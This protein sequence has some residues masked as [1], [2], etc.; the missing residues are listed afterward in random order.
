MMLSRSARLSARAALSR[1]APVPAPAVSRGAR[2]LSTQPAEE[3]ESDLKGLSKEELRKRATA[4]AA[5]ERTDS[6]GRPGAARADDMQDAADKVQSGKSGWQKFMSSLVDGI[7]PVTKALAPGL[8]PILD[9]PSQRRG[10]E[11]ANIDDLRIAAE[12]RAHAMVFGYLAGGADDERS[13]RR[14]VAAYNDVELR[15][16][17]LH[18]VGNAD[19]DLT[20]KILGH[21]HPLPFFITS[22]AGQRMFHADG[23]VATAKAAKKHN[24]HMALS[25]LTTVRT[26]PH[27]VLNAPP[28]P[29]RKSADAPA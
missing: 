11:A 16:A 21:T 26:V 23:E 13:L 9:A 2:Q 1:A 27:P 28:P 3:P 10:R 5:A 15:H 17:V 8:M 29:A 6:G 12:K 22:C 25:Q 19:M 18:G 4:K 20:T 14:S 7:R 24:L